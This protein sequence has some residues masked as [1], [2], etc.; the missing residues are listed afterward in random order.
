MINDVKIFK[1]DKDGKLIYQKKVSGAVLAEIYWGQFKIDPHRGGTVYK[2]KV[3]YPHIGVSKK[4]IEDNCN[5][6]VDDARRKTC[7]LRCQTKRLN[8]Q[9]LTSKLKQR[10]N[11]GR[12][13]S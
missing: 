11:N 6:M 10:K 4:C 7:S 13:N 2:P 1:P 9:R 3:K 8:R 12:L 5:T